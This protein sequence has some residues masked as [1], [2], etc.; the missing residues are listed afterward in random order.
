M[1]I[2]DIVNIIDNMNSGSD[3][4]YHRTILVKAQILA[5]GVLAD[6]LDQIATALENIQDNG[7]PEHGS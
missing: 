7:V 1:V 6:K 5:M 2:N 3:E 4:E